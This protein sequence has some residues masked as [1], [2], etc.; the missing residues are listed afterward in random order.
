MRMMAD[1]TQ[2]T[3]AQ[4]ILPEDRERLRNTNYP[5]RSDCVDGGSYTTSCHKLKKRITKLDVVPIS[6]DWYCLYRK[7]STT[8][9]VACLLGLGQECRD[10]TTYFT[11]QKSFKFK[12]FGVR[13][14]K[15]INPDFIPTFFSCTIE[16][17]KRQKS[18]L[19]KYVMTFV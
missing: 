9:I 7:C 5:I 4:R 3:R 17:R 18:V 16:S 6:F 14:G 8:T 11:T 12:T 19:R 2:V 1:E 15:R 13:Q 10:N